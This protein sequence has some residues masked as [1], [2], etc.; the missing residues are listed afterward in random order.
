M[1]AGVIFD[2]KSPISRKG[3]E[4]TQVKS[5][6][7]LTDLD[8]GSANNNTGTITEKSG[9][10]FGKTYTFKVETYTNEEPKDQ[11]LIKWAVSYTD[12]ETNQYYKNTL[13]DVVTGDTLNIT[14][15]NQNMCGNNL[16]V[17]AYINDIENEGK[18][19]L[20]KHN[21]FR[22]FDREIIKKD[23]NKRKVDPWLINQDDTNTCGPS[24]IMYAFAKKDKESYSQFI[25][26]LHRK[27]YAK[28]NNY[29]I[30]IS[31]DGDL[32]DI[33]DTNPTT[34]NNYPTSMASCDWI[35]NI[36]ITDQENSLFDYEGDTKE[37]F[38]AITL[39]LR[40]EKLAKSLLGYTDVID[41]TNLYFRKS[42]WVWG[43]TLE[44]IAELMNSK[45]AGYEVFLLVNMGLF[46]DTISGD[47]SLPQHWIVLESI[48]HSQTD[49]GYVDISIYTWG[50]NPKIKYNYNKIRYEVFRTNYFG[51]VKAK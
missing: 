10:I 15:K 47:F 18:L 40:L 11:S 46:N 7:L 51:Y 22:F 4:P 41:N 39:P 50:R 36:C 44:N 34:K 43:S 19:P 25:L 13:E 14:F 9:I 32:E 21:R 38:S 6:K 29:S 42:G 24:A 28:H 26:D 12:S 1:G 2:K 27:G 33:A 35:P 5:I 45:E 30:D 17:K 31:S 23:T 49:S 16:E 8:D 3:I 20:F 48:S 37:D